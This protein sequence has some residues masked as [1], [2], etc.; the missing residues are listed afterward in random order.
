[1]PDQLTTTH[2]ASLQ[3]SLGSVRGGYQIDNSRQ[4]NRQTGREEADFTRT[5]HSVS[6]VVGLSTRVELSADVG[7]EE[8]LSEESDERLE[9]RRVGLTGSLG[10]W[11]NARVSVAGTR[12]RSSDPADSGA[13]REV[14][15]F[16]VE[17]TQAVT[18]RRRGTN[19]V[20]GGQLFVRYGRQAGDLFGLAVDHRP[21][22]W[23]LNSGL[24]L[25]L[26]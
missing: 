2:T 20:T 17:W 9:T 8:A 26:F 3:W 5:A 1:V 11:S 15:Q 7:L 14:D 18:L 16:R 23:T 25:R 4:D 24:N 19:A 21:S 22:S 12:T 10:L 6:A 13:R